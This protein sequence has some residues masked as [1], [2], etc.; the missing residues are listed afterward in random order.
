MPNDSPA[1]ELAALQLNLPSRSGEVSILRDIDL[2]ID[3][4]EQVAIVG[5][6]GSG[7][8][9]LLM[10]ISGLEQASS[11]QVTVV[12]YD[13]NQANE[14]RLALFRRQHIGIVFQSFH[15]VPTMTALENVMVPLELSGAT[16]AGAQAASLLEE[17]GLGHRTT[18]YP[19][20]LS[21]GEQQRVALARAF[22]GKPS[23][24]LADEPTGNLDGETGE[25]VIGLLF[26]L[27]ARYGTTLLL[28]THDMQLAERCSR[29]V[30]LEDGR[31]KEDVASSRRAA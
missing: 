21:G 26:D 31:I 18:H 24:L 30:R 12:G 27:S 2:I 22:A 14:D 10:V 16:D 25:K 7:K 5:P 13:M 17:M 1:I 20:E 3:Q 6:S 28:I 11:G 15:L 29:L 23:V 8:T 4:G 9:S 19:A